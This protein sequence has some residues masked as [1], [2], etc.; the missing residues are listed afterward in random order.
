M[1]DFIG[2]KR[3]RVVEDFNNKRKSSS[4]S[5]EEDNSKNDTVTN[6]GNQIRRKRLLDVKD[7]DPSNKVIF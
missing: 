6:L 1:I 5:S 3:Q 4:E 2:G 7:T